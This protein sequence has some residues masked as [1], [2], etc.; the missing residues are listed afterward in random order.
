MFSRIYISFGLVPL[1]ALLVLT[2]P[3]KFLLG[4]FASILIHEC[5]HLVALRI[6]DVK[7]YRIYFR[8]TGAEISTEPISCGKELICAAAGPIGSFITVFLI[9]FFPLF[10]LCA[11]VH[12]LFNCIPLGA[13][14][15]ARVIYCGLRMI[16]PLERA[17]V[18][19][20][21][22]QRLTILFLLIVLV[23]TCV[24]YPVLLKYVPL[25]LLVVIGKNPC[26]ATRKRVQYL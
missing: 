12:G 24:I 10:S 9:R 7:I 25:A 1:F 22:I 21:W 11:I 23:H 8:I 4:L 13:M 5:F 3:I 18:V 20:R 16:L 15:G 2:L 26:K 14:D 6:C 17:H 19:F